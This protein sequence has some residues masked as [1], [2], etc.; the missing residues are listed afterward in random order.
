[1]TQQTSID[2]YYAAKESGLITKRQLEVIEYMAGIS[3]PI[4]QGMITRAYGDTSRSFGPRFGELEARGVIECTGKKLDSWTSRWSK[5]YALTGS[6][7]T[8]PAKRKK[9]KKLTHCPHCGEDLKAKP[10]H[11]PIKEGWTHPKPS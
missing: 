2:A 4:T 7:P 3:G 5:A 6:I 1:M 8:Q 9:A 10:E 11:G